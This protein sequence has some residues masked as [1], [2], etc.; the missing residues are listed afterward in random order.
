VLLKGASEAHSQLLAAVG[1]WGP[2]LERGHVFSDLPAAIA[3]AAGHVSR[4]AGS[5][6]LALPLRASDPAAGP[7]KPG[8]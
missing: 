6:P 5:G 8:R 2:A 7:F 3:H 4:T 1:T